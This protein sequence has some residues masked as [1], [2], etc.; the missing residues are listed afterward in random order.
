MSEHY[1]GKLLIGSGGWLYQEDAEPFIA[2][3]DASNLV[4]TQGTEQEKADMRRIA[5]CWNA[6]RG[7]LTIRLEKAA[8]Y[9]N[10]TGRLDLLAW[11]ARNAAQGR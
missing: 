4:A 7:I 2:H 8:E 5:A 3:M 1:E 6:C 9:E 10:D 11:H